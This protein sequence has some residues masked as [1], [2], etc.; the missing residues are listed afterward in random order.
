M[1]KMRISTEREIIKNQTEIKELKNSI[2][3][4]NNRIGTSRGKNQ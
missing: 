1:N 4:F 2:K 3:D